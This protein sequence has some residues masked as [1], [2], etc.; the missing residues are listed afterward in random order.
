MY[1]GGADRGDTAAIGDGEAALT[2]KDDR[3]EAKLLSPMTFEALGT[4]Y[5]TGAAEVPI[6]AAT[7]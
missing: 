2:E 1:G 4:M 5:A 3:S 7:G 6:T